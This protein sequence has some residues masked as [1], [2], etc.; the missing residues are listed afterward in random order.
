MQNKSLA[1]SITGE[2]TFKN[3]QEVF[4]LWRSCVGVPI[5]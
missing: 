5:S 3:F 4:N 2:K 1:V